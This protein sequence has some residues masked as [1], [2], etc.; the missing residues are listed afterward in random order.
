M[1]H[2]L[3]T[4]CGNRTVLILPSPTSTLPKS[5]ETKN[6]KPA[7]MPIKHETILKDLRHE[8][9]AEELRLSELRVKVEEKMQNAGTVKKPR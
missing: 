1:L 6:L 9:Y 7:Q 5:Q 2:K 8:R 4:F 3:S